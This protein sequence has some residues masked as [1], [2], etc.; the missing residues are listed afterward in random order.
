MIKEPDYNGRHCLVG[1]SC[2]KQTNSEIINREIITNDQNIPVNK[3]RNGNTV[4]IVMFFSEFE[5]SVEV[6]II[7]VGYSPL[8]TDCRATCDMINETMLLEDRGFLHSLPLRT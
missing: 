7:I 4:V 2:R 1:G 6:S 8:G 5:Y 3:F